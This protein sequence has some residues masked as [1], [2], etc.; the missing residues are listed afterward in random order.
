MT[1][2][3]ATVQGSDECPLCGTYGPLA[4]CGDRL[5]CEA[6]IQSRELEAQTAQCTRTHYAF[7]ERRIGGGG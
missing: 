7:S 6:C 4:L 5:L 3:A 1:L 2:D